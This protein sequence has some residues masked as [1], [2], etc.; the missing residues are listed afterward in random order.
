MNLKLSALYDF[1][2]QFYPDEEKLNEVKKWFPDNL[3]DAVAE[4]YKDIL[5]CDS[6]DSQY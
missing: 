2:F 1:S 6:G 5:D 3:T 4:K